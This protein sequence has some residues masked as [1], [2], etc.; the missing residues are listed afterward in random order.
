MKEELVKIYNEG[1][2]IFGYP[3]EYKG[4]LL[5]PIKIKDTKFR[6]LL[7]QL[8]AQPKLYI[9]NREVLKSS[10]LK[11]LIY[12]VQSSIKNEDICQNL[13]AFMEYATQIKEIALQYKEVPGKEGLDSVILQLKIGEKIITEEEFDDIREI[14]LQQNGLTIDYVEEY[15]PEL[16]AHLSFTLKNST[17]ITFEDEVF[18]FCAMMN[19]TMKDIEN[20][21]VYQFRQH[22]EKLLVLKEYDLY[23]PLLVSGQITLKTGEIKPYLYHSTRGG[24]YDSIKM[25]VG[26]FE[27]S[28]KENKEQPSS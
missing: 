26:K 15:N 13:I 18:T 16:E 5:Y 3:Q 22:F 24:R 25:D 9:P 6:T 21:T 8:F 10:Y 11:F 19:V 23:K 14:V 28:L 20:Y 17:D 1:N 7:Y 2:D 4:L 12:V 27:N